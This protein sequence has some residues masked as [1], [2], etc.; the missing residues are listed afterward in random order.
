MKQ[1][2]PYHLLA[3]ILTG[4]A[5][6]ILFYLAFG[7]FHAAGFVIWSITTG[8]VGGLA[9]GLWLRSIG[10]TIGITMFIRVVVFAAGSGLFVF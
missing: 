3:G 4:F 7:V 6:S 2:L 1:N 5:L 10:A 8:V 9:G